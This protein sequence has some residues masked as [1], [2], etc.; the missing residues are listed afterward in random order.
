MKKIL[1]NTADKVTLHEINI[2]DIY[3]HRNK[4]GPVFSKGDNSNLIY[5]LISY[6]L[7]CDF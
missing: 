5:Y 6:H 2:R 7:S 4:T 3:P 1:N